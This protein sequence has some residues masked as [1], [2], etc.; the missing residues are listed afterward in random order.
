MAYKP[1]ARGY[2][3][4]MLVGMETEFGKLPAGAAGWKI[5]FNTESLTISRAKNTAA[6]LRGTRN[7]AEP[8]DGNTAVDGDLVVPVDTST[9]GL[10]LSLLFGTP[11][12]EAQE[13]ETGLYTHTFASGEELPSFWT[14]VM[15]ATQTPIYKRS[16]GCKISTL[17]LQA[18]GDGEL[19]ATL[20]LM[21]ASQTQESA[22]AVAAPEEM[23]FN[24][25]ANFQAL[26]KVDGQVTGNAMSFSVNLDNGL[27]GEVRL[28]SGQG[29]RADLPEGLMG[30]SGTMD[31]M[32]TDGDL[33]AK[34]L[35]STP[36]DLELSFTK[37]QES[38]TIKLPK[39]QLQVTGPVID[40]PAG[41]KM[42]WNWQAYSV[43]PE[44]A[45][46]TVEL[47]N[48]LPDYTPGN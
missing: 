47:V 14:E 9:F 5:P 11:S 34:A 32:V 1:A 20:G 41:L 27:D 22:A 46:M 42:S 26:L 13:G 35:A 28:L 23:P 45:A 36:L 48:T 40:G 24:R 8:F 19:T 29:F 21:A 31:V 43:Q 17:A 6:T 10:W 39:V 2:R 30:V 4:E 25:L 44:D 37:G 15:I 7:P 3:G 33:Y 12:S 38:L 16:L 18:G